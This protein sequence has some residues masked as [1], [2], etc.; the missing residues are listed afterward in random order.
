MNKHTRQIIKQMLVLFQD[1]RQNKIGLKHL[2]DGLEGGIN[3]IEENLPK[4][5]HDQWFINWGRLEETLAIGKENEYRT[6][7]FEDITALET[8]LNTS[9][10]ET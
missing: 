1:Y 10:N 7:I 8:M 2:V 9:L 3:A 4:T 6:D 5:F